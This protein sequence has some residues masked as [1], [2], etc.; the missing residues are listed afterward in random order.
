VVLFRKAREG[1]VES[2]VL[3]LKAMLASKRLDEDIELRP[4]DMLFVPQNRI[5]K[6]KKFLPV[7]SLSTFFTPAQF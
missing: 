4:G 6:I 3:D 5:S 1:F 7:A 2:H